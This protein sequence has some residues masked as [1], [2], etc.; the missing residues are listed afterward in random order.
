M[1]PYF[2]F[3]LCIKACIFLSNLFNTM[4]HIEHWYKPYQIIDRDGSGGN[5]SLIFLHLTNI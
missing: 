4:Q 2:Q 1:N 3:D 5:I